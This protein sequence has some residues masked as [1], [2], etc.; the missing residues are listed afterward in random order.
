[1]SRPDNLDKEA[2]IETIITFVQG[3]EPAPIWNTWYVGT[4][5]DPTI[6]LYAEHRASYAKSVYVSVDSASTARATEKYLISRYGMDGK[7][8][9]KNHPRVVYAFKK[10]P[11][12]DPPL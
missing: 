12:T 10:L 2:A 1:M 7:R 9:G 4:T 11:D 5:D 6:R 8:G 3:L